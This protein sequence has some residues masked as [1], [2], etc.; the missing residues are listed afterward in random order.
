MPL[1]KLRLT[2]FKIRIAHDARSKT[3][4]EAFKKS[5]IMEEWEKTIWYQKMQNQK[6]V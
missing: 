5:N 4:R 3:V 1:Y 6:K 2:D